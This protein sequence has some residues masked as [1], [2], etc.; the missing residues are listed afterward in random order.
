MIKVCEEHYDCGECSRYMEQAIKEAI[1]QEHIRC[2]KVVEIQIRL[3]APH[4]LALGWNKSPKE[5]F[6]TIAVNMLNPEANCV[7][8]DGAKH[9]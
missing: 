6:S 9:D 7:E 4:G 8:S 2:L 5:L 1:E 3:S